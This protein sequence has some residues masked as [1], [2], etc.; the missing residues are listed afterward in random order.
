VALGIFRKEHL[1]ADQYA[2]ELVNDEDVIEAIF[3]ELITRDFINNKY[4]PKISQ[5]ARCSTGRDI[6]PHGKMVDVVRNTLKKEVYTRFLAEV[7]DK[8]E[9][10]KSSYPAL[11]ERVQ[12]LGHYKPLFPSHISETAAECYLDNKLEKIIE[13]MDEKWLMKYGQAEQN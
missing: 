8:P 4:F 6:L 13:L 10:Y 11:T 7:P 3:L 12:N 9:D 5:I 1:K 2:L